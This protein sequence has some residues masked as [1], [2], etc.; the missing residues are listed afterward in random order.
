VD[1]KWDAKG[2]VGAK[3]QAEGLDIPKYLLKYFA[4]PISQVS[5]LKWV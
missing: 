4:S 3:T 2:M 5:G 1:T